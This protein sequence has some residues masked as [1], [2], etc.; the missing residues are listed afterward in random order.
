MMLRIIDKETK[1]FL[2]DDFT[3]DADLEIGLDVEPAQGFILPKWS[4]SNNTWIES[5]TEEQ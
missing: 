4:E 2:R 3:F 1:I 5:S